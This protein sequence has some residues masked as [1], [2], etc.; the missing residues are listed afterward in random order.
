L[1]AGGVT[2]VEVTLRTSQALDALVAMCEGVPELTV[3][4]GTVLEE[5]QV[6]QVKRA[7]AAFAVAPGCSPSIIQAAHSAGL[8]FAP[9]VATPSDIEQAMRLGCRIL[10]FF[11]AEPSGGLGYLK[12]VAAPYAHLGIQFIP[13][14][15]LREEHIKG[16]AEEPSVLAVGGSFIATPEALSARDFAAVTERAKNAVRLVAEARRTIS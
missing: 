3:G 15:G 11:P 1:L 16:Y 9:G 8:P 6:E 13:L 2:A 14:G 5:R 10:K 4:A 7:G 12:A